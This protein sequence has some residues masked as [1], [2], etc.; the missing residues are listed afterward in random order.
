M[1]QANLH[2]SLL[3]NTL[4]HLLDGVT[5]FSL[6]RKR[7]EPAFDFEPAVVLASC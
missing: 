7:C 4:V 3:F 2:T 1:S 5:R 6:A